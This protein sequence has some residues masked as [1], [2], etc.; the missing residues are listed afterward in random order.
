[1]AAQTLTLENV[2]DIIVRTVNHSLDGI[3]SQLCDMRIERKV[4]REEVK[5]VSWEIEE[6][7]VKLGNG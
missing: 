1:M 4:L 6:V 7:K 5:K 2:H 3:R